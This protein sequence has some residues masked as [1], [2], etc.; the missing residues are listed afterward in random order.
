MLRSEKEVLLIE[1]VLKPLKKLA[2]YLN[3]HCRM[4]KVGQEG[5]LK[6]FAKFIIKS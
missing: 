1:K 3:L 5:H 6:C 4:L 2:F